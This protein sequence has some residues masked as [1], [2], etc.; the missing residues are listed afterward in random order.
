MALFKRTRRVDLG[1]FV[2]PEPVEPAPVERVVEEGLLIAMTALRMQVKN[3]MIVDAIRNDNSYDPEALASVA[4]AELETMAAQN[5][6]LA[7][8][9]LTARNIAIYRGLADAL[10]ELAADGT[11][12]SEVVEQSREE[13]WREVSGAVATTLAA[14]AVDPR[15]PAYEEEKDARIRDL[16]T[17]DL[18]RL[19]LESLP[20]Y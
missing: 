15:D 1:K 7:R 17:V 3:S 4:R 2:A 5:V 18:A 20:E 12:I 16:L 11:R 13:A 6:R 10:R 9:Q 14:R 8:D 19:E